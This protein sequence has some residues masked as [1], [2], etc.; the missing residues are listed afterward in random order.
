[1]I[2]KPFKCKVDNG[3][4]GKTE[5]SFACIKTKLQNN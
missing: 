4:H 3:E 1:M 5:A 2:E